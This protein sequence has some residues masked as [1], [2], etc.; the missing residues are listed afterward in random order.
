[1]TG[2]R[3]I[4]LVRFRPEAREDERR[5]VVQAIEALPSLVP[6]IRA[7]RAGANVGTSPAAYDLAVVMDFDDRAAFERYL[8]SD[9]HR[10]YASGPAARAVGGLAVVQ[11]G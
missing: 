11:H 3:H 6:E 7:L 9:A 2:F 1:M 4:V 10:A 5:A 8:A